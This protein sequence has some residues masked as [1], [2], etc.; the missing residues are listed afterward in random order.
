MSLGV[1]RSS[2]STLR[3][4]P[5]AIKTRP[6]ANLNARELRAPHSVE[7]ENLMEK[8]TPQEKANSNFLSR[9][10]PSLSPAIERDGACDRPRPND[11]E[12][13]RFQPGFVFPLAC[14]QNFLPLQKA[15]VPAGCF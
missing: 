10:E 5:L 12:N 8:S 1:G 2:K 13:E 7:Y 3:E 4:S 11:G 14:D 6:V 9:Q 15:A